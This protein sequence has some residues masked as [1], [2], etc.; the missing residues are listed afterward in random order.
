MVPVIVENE[1]NILSQYTLES[2]MLYRYLNMPC[3]RFCLDNFKN[4]EHYAACGYMKKI[5]D[6]EAVQKIILRPAIKGI[7]YSNTIYRFIGIHLGLQPLMLDEIK[8]KFQMFSIRNKYL[9]TVFFPVLKEDLENDILHSND[10]F[11]RLIKMLNKDTISAEDEQLINNNLVNNANANVIDIILYR[12]IVKKFSKFNYKSLSAKD[13][14][15]QAFNNFQDA[16][17]HITKRRKNHAEFKINDEYDVQDLSYLIFRSIFPDLQYENPHFKS[18]GTNSKVDLMIVSEGI[19]IELKMIKESNFDEKEIIK[20]LKIDIN[21]YATW[22]ELKHLIV[23]VY[24]PL[25][26]TS[27]RNNFYELN[28]QK[29]IF[30]TTFDVTVI[31]SN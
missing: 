19:D 23:F 22:R 10:V 24:D 16:V 27:N 28:G 20:Q 4:D 8:A 14:I 30:G 17:K 21:D 13:L 29:M 25:N 31:V 1:K 6:I 3:D 5:L 11:S 15:I 7:D 12:E 18:G 2:L 9:T 26:K